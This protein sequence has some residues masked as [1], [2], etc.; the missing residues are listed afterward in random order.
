M[1]CIHSF[2]VIAVMAFRR[3]RYVTS[4]YIQYIATNGCD[5]YDYELC[6]MGR[7]D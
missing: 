4:E 6:D 7:V 2:S 1:Y 5:I 3:L